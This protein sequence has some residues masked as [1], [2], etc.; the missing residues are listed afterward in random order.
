M[1]RK[2][3]KLKLRE[4]FNEWV[5]SIDDPLIR[6]RVRKN[7]I[8][9]GGSIAS[10]LSG[11][12]VND[13]D[14][15]FRDRTTVELIV[16]YYLEKFKATYGSYDMKKIIEEDR[17]KIYIPSVGQAGDAPENEDEE[18]TGEELEEFDPNAEAE[19]KPK[20]RPVFVTANAITLSDKVQL[21]IRFYGEPGEIHE[22]Y[23][24]IHC[25]GY[26]T[27]WDDVVVL[28]EAMLESLITRELRYVGS[29]YP[30][31]S[32]IRTRKFVKRGWKINAGQY[33]KMC[34]QLNELD[35]TDLEVLE[36]QLTGV[37]A[38][39]FMQVINA[40]KEG[41]RDINAAYLCTIIDRIF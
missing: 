24:F 2:T 35:L 15:Y 14:L 33:L 41:G 19:P 18:Y 25:T 12:P 9:T 39:Y 38:A 1:L 10:M 29:L 4:L 27:S 7:T 40:V 16:D 13:Y 34:M 20:F 21:V 17:V 32:I 8:I 3:I 30:L 5:E 23:D 11:E 6:D 37:D 22:N 36:D 28:N 31:C 26:W